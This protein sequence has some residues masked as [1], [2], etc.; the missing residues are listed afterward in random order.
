MNNYLNTIFDKIY[1]IG[2]RTRIDR[3]KAMIAR[4]SHTN[5]DA[6]R[7]EGIQGGHIDQSTLDFGSR[8]RV[9]NNGE[10]GCYLSHVELFKKIKQHK[11]K[12]TLILEDDAMIRSVT[13]SEIKEIYEH[14]PAYDLLYFGHNNYD[15]SS[16]N[17]TVSLKEKISLGV[18]KANNCWLTHAYA[19][20]L[21]C[22]DYLI[23]NTRQM[24]SCID[25]VLSDIQKDL[26]VYA[27]YP[28]IINQDGSK[29][30]IRS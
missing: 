11:Y 29:S 12:K 30:S 4:L 25:N 18:F 10:I 1:W 5:L 22:V 14:V 15:G 9:L 17:P 19:V 23:G 3:H 13:A 7:F 16:A 27:V 26:R 2:T 6:E 28:C 8:K 20:D 24:Y 21:D